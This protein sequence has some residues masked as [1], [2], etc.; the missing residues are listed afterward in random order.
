MGSLFCVC[1]FFFF[2]GPYLWH[3]EVPR[4]RELPAYA[5]ATA[6]PDLSHICNLPLWGL[7]YKNTNP[8]RESSTI[9]TKYLLKTQP[10]NNTNTLGTRIS[11]YGFLGNTNI[12]TIVQDLDRSGVIGRKK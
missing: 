9:M 10:P 6:K 2:L 1:L 5:I 7:F 3:K 4:L 12:H 11:A 8:I